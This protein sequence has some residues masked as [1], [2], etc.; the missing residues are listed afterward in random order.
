MT[1]TPGHGTFR[2]RDIERLSGFGRVIVSAVPVA[3][4]AGRGG[5]H[6]RRS[7]RSAISHHITAKRSHATSPPPG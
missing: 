5:E 4:I 1:G 2:R 3:R 6:P 7:P